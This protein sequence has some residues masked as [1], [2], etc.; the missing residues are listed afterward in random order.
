MTCPFLDYRAQH[1]ETTFEH[2]RPY[3][4]AIDQ[5]VQPMRADIC[6][7]RYDLHHESDC[8]IFLDHHR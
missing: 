1:G 6:N 8:E 3:C 4:T 5:F 7:N 2:E